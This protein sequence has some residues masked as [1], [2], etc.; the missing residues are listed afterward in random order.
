MVLLI[1]TSFKK[2]GRST[3]FDDQTAMNTNDTNALSFEIS[4]SLIDWISRSMMH[5]GTVP[6][7][8]FRHPQP[9]DNYRI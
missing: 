4:E 6:A 1:Y 7:K 3:L 8:P 9:R 5:Q 2:V